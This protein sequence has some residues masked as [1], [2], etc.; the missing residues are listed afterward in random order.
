MR[1]LT[2]F[3]VLFLSKKTKF[4]FKKDNHFTIGFSLHKRI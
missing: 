2:F 1:L 3:F 4:T